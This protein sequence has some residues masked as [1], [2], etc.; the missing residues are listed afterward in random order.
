[1]EVV[2]VILVVGRAQ[3]RAEALAGAGVDHAQ[4][5]ALL[6]GALRPVLLYA[7]LFLSA[8]GDVK[9]GQDHTEVLL[10]LRAP[11]QSKKDAATHQALTI[12]GA[13]THF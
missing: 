9:Q 1:V 11:T 10:P 13:P 3:H 6:R 8:K 7:D 2:G 5:L 12:A 4:E